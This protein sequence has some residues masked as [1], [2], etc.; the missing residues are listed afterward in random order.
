LTEEQGCAAVELESAR[1][2]LQ[3]AH[4][5]L[6]TVIHLRKL[7]QRQ[8]SGKSEQSRLWDRWGQTTIEGGLQ[9]RISHSATIVVE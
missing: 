7:E 1:R 3:C 4:R 2:P 8:Q 6:C 9:A 5:G